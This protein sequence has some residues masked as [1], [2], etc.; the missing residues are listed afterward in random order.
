MKT[1]TAT[2]KIIYTRKLNPKTKNCR[3]CKYFKDNFYNAF[4]IRITDKTNAKICSRL[5]FKKPR[6]KKKRKYNKYNKNK[7]KK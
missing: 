2:N 3:N 1:G 6:S 7:N 4:E 5:T